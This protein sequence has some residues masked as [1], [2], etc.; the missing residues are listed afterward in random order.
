MNLKYKRIVS[1]VISIACFFLGNTAFAQKVTL[2]GST[3]I[4]KRVL[5]PG[6]KALFKA[7][8]IKLIVSGTG[9]GKGLALLMRGKVK[10]NASLSSSPLKSSIKSGEKVNKKPFSGIEQLQEHVITEDVIV[11]I[12]HKS[13]PITKLS[14]QQLSD[15]NTGKIK[16][17]KELGGPNLPI[18]VVTSHEG[19]ATRAVFQ[20]MVMKKAK[21]LKRA[22]TVRSTRQEVGQVTKYKGGIGAVSEGFLKLNPGKVKEIKTK[23]ISRPLSIITRGDPDPVVQ[24]II[25]FYRSDEAKKLYR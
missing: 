7:T 23:R 9:T 16:N 4:Q 22:R 8:G 11:P 25:D 10:H 15:I 20:K 5:E 18:I 6:A 2:P 3:T 14:W 19:S 17:W 1:L 24:K 13:N 21:Y 12:V